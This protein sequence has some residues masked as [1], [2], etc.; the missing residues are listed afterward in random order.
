M[1]LA[2]ARG[3]AYS[4]A[5]AKACTIVLILALAGCAGMTPYRPGPSPCDAGEATHACQVERY[6]NVN[7]Q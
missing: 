1:V 7:A 4:S 2:G 3:P 5:M 6:N